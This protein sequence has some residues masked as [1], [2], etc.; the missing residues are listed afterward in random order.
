MIITPEAGDPDII[1]SHIGN[2]YTVEVQPGT[3]GGSAAGA[4]SAINGAVVSE[5]SENSLDLGIHN[6]KIM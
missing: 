5:L 1:T 6:I 4:I 3:G 2:T